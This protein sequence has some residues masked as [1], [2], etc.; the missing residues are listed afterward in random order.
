LTSVP[1]CCILL[2]MQV[3]ITNLVWEEAANR[4]GAEE[5]GEGDRAASP[6]CAAFLAILFDAPA[7]TPRGTVSLEVTPEQARAFGQEVLMSAVNIWEWE[8]YDTPN[9]RRKADRMARKLR[10][11]INTYGGR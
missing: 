1:V 6:E 3:K 9:E 5:G 4:Y 11:W 10:E 8:D 7:P 2:G